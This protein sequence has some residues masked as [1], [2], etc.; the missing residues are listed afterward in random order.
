MC[1]FLLRRFHVVLLAVLGALFA[2]IANAA[3]SSF[4]A[5]IFFS[6]H[7]A[8]SSEQG[9]FFIGTLAGPGVASKVGAATLDS[10]DCIVPLSA[11]LFMFSSQRAVLTAHGDEIWVAYGGFLSTGDGAITGVYQINGGTGR[12]ANATGEGTL[13]GF[14]TLDLTAFS[15][16]GQIQL[17]G[18]L[19]Y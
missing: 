7:V 14:E 10:S 12:F 8:P 16:F 1:D 18:T 4:Q 9:C 19:S 15:G 5:T 3:P 2:P 6:E 17:T 11:T 13:K